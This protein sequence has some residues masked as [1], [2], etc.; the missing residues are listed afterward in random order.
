[1]GAALPVLRNRRDPVPGPLG[2]YAK[3]SL[4]LL[5]ESGSSSEF[6]K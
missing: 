5:G 2:P 6:Q 1:M 4:K 3:R